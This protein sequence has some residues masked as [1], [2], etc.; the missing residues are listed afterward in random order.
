MDDKELYQQKKQ[1]QLDEWK[2]EIDKLKAKA[3]GA[4]A[5]V[6]LEMN[7]QIKTI[8]SKVIE[9][10]KKLSELAEAGEDAWESIKEGVESAWNSLKSAVSDA[11]AKFKG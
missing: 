5:D 3:S 4:S 6:Q 9:G 2:A 10:K 7:K 1:A 8:E 11:A